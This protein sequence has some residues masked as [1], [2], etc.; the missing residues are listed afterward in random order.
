MIWYRTP[1]FKMIN[2]N[3]CDHFEVDNS[4][5]NFW[6]P[7]GILRQRYQS[8]EVSV[9]V[10]DILCKQ[11]QHDYKLNKDHMKTAMKLAETQL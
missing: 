9:E 1:D 6:F 5:I 7:H 3:M 4:F 8:N 10:F 11:I 2:L